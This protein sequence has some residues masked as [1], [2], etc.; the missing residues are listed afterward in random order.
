M[1]AY[2]ILIKKNLNNSV[3]FVFFFSFPFPFSSEHFKLKINVSNDK[4]VE[5]NHL[6]KITKKVSKMGLVTNDVVR[7][8]LVVSSNFTRHLLGFQRRQEKILVKNIY[9]KKLKKKFSRWSNSLISSCCFK[10]EVYLLEA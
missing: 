4:T 6:T 8:L 1:K 9:M 7:W 5:D 10:D 3:S 2:L